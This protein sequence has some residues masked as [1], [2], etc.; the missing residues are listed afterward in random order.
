M[1]N[2]HILHFT[3]GP[4]QGFIARARRT[5]DLWAGS[6][7]LSYL[8]GHAMCAVI[9][10]QGEIIFPAV[11]DDN[12]KITDDL[13]RA[14]KEV[15]E[16]ES[17]NEQPLV[18]TLPNRFQ[19]LVPEDFNPSECTQAVQ[20]AWERIAGMVW[21]RFVAPVAEKGA[22][23]EEIW[24]RQV[25]G[26]WEMNWA[27]GDDGSCLDRRKNW[28]SHVPTV[29][30]GDKCTIMGNLQEISGYIRS[31]KE[32][33]EKQDLFW[34]ELRSR[35]RE[36]EIGEGERLCAVSLVKRLF[37]LVAEGTIGWRVR[38]G[39]PSTSY[40]AAVPWLVE[41]MNKEQDK[42]GRFLSLARRDER[43]EPRTHLKESSIFEIEKAKREHPE[44]AGFAQCDGNF[45]FASTL[46]NDSLWLEGTG[47]TRR[48]LADML[49]KFAVK[50]ATYYAVLMVD[51]D[52]LG[53]LLRKADPKVV[54]NS[55]AIFADK[56]PGIVNRYSG[57]LVYAGGD[58]V[59]ALL[60]A[61]HAVALAAELRRQYKQAFKNTGIKDHLA[62][63][64]AAV[65]YAHHHAPLKAVLGEAHT[66]LDDVAK[67]RTGR[68]SLAVRVWNTG[69][70]G[71]LWS[72]PWE[73]ILE[74]DTN[75]LDSL[76]SDFT[77]ATSGEKQYN[78]AFFYNI[79][80]RFSMLWSDNDRDNIELPDWDNIL[81]DLFLAEYLRSRE[82]E[83]I[84]RN[85]ARRRVERLLKVCRKYRRVAPE[86]GESPRIEEA[87]I[88][89]DGAM[90]VRFLT[91]KGGTRDE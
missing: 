75:L 40:I 60:T 84:D 15:E 57:V 58:D 17:T 51:G 71:L 70:P 43:L 13:L 64:S 3:L 62:T 28:R 67:D 35:V 88:S 48:D 19:A 89:M 65:V 7:L 44:V 36:L 61:Q 47:D 22:G 11:L 26:F 54:S 72:A 37:P 66:L 52:L 63:V 80:H 41:T 12:R 9:Q 49:K 85:E 16:N 6:F 38:T 34:Q 18:G 30:H 59:L 21:E 24:R 79:R 10:K 91:G 20:Q 46:A 56:V 76:V 50:P 83:N 25:K 32:M 82:R 69:G 4:V 14:I 33:R 87:G 2:K 1:D 74:G 73:E 29:E 8:A 55:L 27:F 23:T 90:L 77:G 5:R 81:A 45:F 78:S 42:A 86:N 68:D 31:Q 53:A 39:Y